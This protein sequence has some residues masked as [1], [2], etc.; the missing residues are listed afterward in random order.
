MVNAVLG[1]RRQIGSLGKLLIP[2]GISVAYALWIYFTDLSLGGRLTSLLSAYFF[3]PFGK[4]SIIPLGLA[5]GY[6]PMLLASSIIMIDFLTA[7]FLA[8]NFTLIY[9]I[10][11]LGWCVRRT[12]AQGKKILVERRW[13]QE[14]LFDWAIYLYGYST[15]GNRSPDHNPNWQ[16]Y[17]A[18]SM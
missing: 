4:E 2:I 10:P 11:L 13:N 12:E 8:W 16:D 18:W 15:S 17:G 6:S 14:V 9:R 7:L 3:P 5:L 1:C